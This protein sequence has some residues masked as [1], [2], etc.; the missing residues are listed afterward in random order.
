VTVF[1]ELMGHVFCLCTIASYYCFL[2]FGASGK[3]ILAF[4][5]DEQIKEVLNQEGVP[6][7]E[8]EQ[9]ISEIER[10]RSEGYSYTFSERKNESIGF[11]AP[12]FDAAHHVVGSIIFA[13]PLSL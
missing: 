11:G 3:V 2:H 4:L 6:L 5:T 10:I 1:S 8:A 13:I 7:D 9:I 12:I